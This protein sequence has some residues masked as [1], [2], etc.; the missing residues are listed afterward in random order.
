MKNLLVISTHSFVDLITNS[1]TELYVCK[2]DKT[3]DAVTEILK[4]LLEG[5]NNITGQ[6]KTFNDCFKPLT[7]AK[8]G[9]DYYGLP[10][11]LKNRYCYY[12]EYNGFG[13][14]NS[15]NDYDS[16]AEKE[17][18]DLREKENK[19]E[20][21]HKCNEKGLYEKDKEEY[22]K[23]QKAYSKD[24][25]ALWTNYGSKELES[26]SNLF[27]EFLKQNEFSQKEINEARKICD[28]SI[29]Y[30]I[31]HKL[32]EYSYLDKNGEFKGKLKD[33]YETFNHWLSW[34][35]SPQKGD[36]L[37]EGAGDNDIPYEI[38]D[39]IESYLNARRYHLG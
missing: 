34:G 9:F 7:I 32:G 24:R 29:K 20:S 13:D 5:H 16:P 25:N 39:S 10:Q 27:I 17:R 3:I 33:A 21:K 15:R 14:Y 18:Q 30:H 2:G 38:M 26:E 6:N 1:S 12:H 23:R 28:N 22:E 19:L 11:E 4:K 31:K 35:I 36:I 8:Y 37:V